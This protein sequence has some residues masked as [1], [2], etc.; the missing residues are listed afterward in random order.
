MMAARSIKTRKAERPEC[1]L[2]LARAR[3]F[4][5]A[6]EALRD[7]DESANSI[8]ATYVLCGIAAA[9]AVC[10]RRLGEYSRSENHADA[11]EL[12]KR[13]D[14]SL[15]PPL[16]RLV[17]DKSADAYGASTVPARRVDQ[18]RTAAKKLLDYAEAM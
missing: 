3:E 5:R 2:R 14:P 11:V 15:A 7:L 18:T 17:S 8:A 16:S 1:D 9:D 12:L 13:V 6:A 10:C 4:S